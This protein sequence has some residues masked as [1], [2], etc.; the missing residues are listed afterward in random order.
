MKQLAAR[1]TADEIELMSGIVIEI[2]TASLS[3]VRGYAVLA[4][5]IDELAFFPTDEN[6]ANID[7]EVITAARPS[8]A[9]IEGAMMFVATAPSS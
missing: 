3:A 4:L 8:M 6:S 7:E 1:E 5:L 9:S 2:H